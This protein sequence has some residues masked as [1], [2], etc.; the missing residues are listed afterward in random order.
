MAKCENVVVLVGQ[1]EKLNVTSDRPN[2]SPAEIAHAFLSFVTMRTK[3]S[4]QQ[5]KPQ[6]ERLTEIDDRTTITKEFIRY[7]NKRLR[8]VEAVWYVRQQIKI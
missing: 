6:H 2:M 8:E 4:Q 7:R 3:P 1:H 5:P